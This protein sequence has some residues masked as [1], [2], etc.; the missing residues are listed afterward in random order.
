[1]TLTGSRLAARRA[2][3]EPL[4]V[5][6]PADVDVRDGL[7]AVDERVDDRRAQ[8]GDGAAGGGRARGGAGGS[9]G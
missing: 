8:L 6:L 1:M 3:D 4:G 5:Q 9:V 7:P 2:G